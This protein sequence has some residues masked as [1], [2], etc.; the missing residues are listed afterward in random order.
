[1]TVIVWGRPC[2]ADT[3]APTELCIQVGDWTLA[4]VVQHGQSGNPVVHSFLALVD[5]GAVPDTSIKAVW[6]VRNGGGV[7]VWTAKTWDAPN[8]WEAIKFVKL[9]LDIG[10]EWDSVWPTS[11]DPS[12]LPVELQEV[13]SDYVSG[14][15][16][17]DPLLGLLT[18]PER[19][20]LIE[21]LVAVGYKA[22][23]IPFEKTTY[24]GQ[25]SSENVLTAY[26][27]GIDAGLNATPETSAATASAA[28]ES[29]MTSL[30]GSWPF[31]F[32]RYTR[33]PWTLVL[34]SVWAPGPWI[35]DFCSP[36]IGG[37]SAC[38]YHT[39]I[40][41][42]WTRAVVIVW[43]NCNTTTVARAGSECWAYTLTCT[44]SDG[45]ACPPTPN[46]VPTPM[47][48]T[49]PLGTPTTGP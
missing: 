2:G 10:D 30:C 11:D 47:P 25:C 7:G 3:F 36:T 14:L 16:D 34:P 23:D 20:M 45:G 13:P 19:D 15:V 42:A 37:C 38:T 18:T 48:T 44:N 5:Q 1:M 21:V 33:G 17:N 31:C 27:I 49:P 39:D 24:T 46:C 9:S 43:P 32:P 12:D 22:A 26:A 4:P 28:T 41:R 35:Y 6:Y 29:S 8:Q 40:C